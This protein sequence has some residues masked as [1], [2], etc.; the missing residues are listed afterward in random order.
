MSTRIQQNAKPFS[1]AMV[2]MW[3]GIKLQTALN[4]RICYIPAV[5][6]ISAVDRWL[7]FIVK[8][9][10]HWAYCSTTHIM[11]P[12][13]FVWFSFAFRTTVSLSRSFPFS[14]VLI[15]F[16]CHR[17]PCAIRDSHSVD[18]FSAVSLQRRTCF[19]ENAY[20]VRTTPWIQRNDP[21]RV[22]AKANDERQ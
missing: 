12:L 19:S 16:H 2:L 6:R 13:I 18:K 8:L 1:G 11:R 14:L 15:R 3:T 9:S 10:I 7:L 21:H 17:I 22:T 20:C 5:Q 4:V